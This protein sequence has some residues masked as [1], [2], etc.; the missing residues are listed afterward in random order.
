MA[1]ATSTREEQVDRNLRYLTWKADGRDKGLTAAPLESK[2][3][4]RSLL[5]F[6]SQYLIK[7]TPISDRHHP[8]FR[9]QAALLKQAMTVAGMSF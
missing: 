7:G 8:A 2:G 3:K 4:A 6:S 9:R 1:I 5:S